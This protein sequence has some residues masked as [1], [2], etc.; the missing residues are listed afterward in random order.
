MASYNTIRTAE[1]QPIG[2][3]VPW[4]GRLTDLPAGWLL[5]NGQELDAND[6]P[7]LARVIKN[8]YG[9]SFSGDFPNYSGTFILPAINQKGLSDI[10]L[11][12]FTDDQAT[13]GAD[14]P[15]FNVD[16]AASLAVVSD[17]IGPEGDIGVPGTVFAV[18]D[19]NFT[20]TADPDGTVLRIIKIAG[21]AADTNIPVFYTNIPA[22]PD[23]A[24]SGGTGALFNVIQ[25][26][27][28]TYQVSIASKGEGYE[29]GE[30]LIISGALLGGVSGANDLIIEIDRIGNPFYTGRIS[31]DGDGAPL[32]FVPGFGIETINVVPRKLGRN[33][34]PSHLHPGQ[35]P[36]INV[37]DSS[38]NPG[39]GVCVW[40]NPT[41]LV[42]EYWYGRNPYIGV[43][44]F[45]Q[46]VF[47]GVENLEVG[48]EWG[49]SLN[50]GEID[51]VLNPFTPGVGRYSLASISGTPPART[52]QPLQTGS[53]GHGV[54]KNWFN[55]AF[56]LRDALDNTTPSNPNLEKVRTTGKFDLGFTIPFS[57][58]S[59]TIT[60]LNYDDGTPAGLGSDDIVPFRQV[61][62]NSAA[63]SFT[64]LNNTAVGNTN[65]IQSHDHQGEIN[66]TF[67]N[68]SLSIPPTIS[69]AV[70][71]NVVPDNLP[72]AF[73]IEFVTSSPSVSCITLIRAY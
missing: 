72:N 48:N 41:V 22:T 33:H 6:Y 55:N 47:A 5:C 11:E 8:T 60:S 51:N 58:Q 67:N 36:T 40:E 2:S 66:I 12:Y 61:F 9:G 50:T 10:S 49:N 57:D 68:G 31:K 37:N 15:T 54:G 39:D 73:Q 14:Q 45:G 44:P 1:S 62:F 52:H 26:T 53:A 20:Y 21:V 35:Y 13:P 46:F 64:Q 24:P 18:T 65:V 59:T 34:F 56:K 25:N 70:V 27:D 38:E 43:V 71:A 42:T 28:N 3:C 30:Q 16:D 17:F 32:E 63:N 4:A 7:L 69:T 23:P 29:E 19:L